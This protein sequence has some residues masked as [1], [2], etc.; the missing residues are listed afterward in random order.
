RT[1]FYIFVLLCLVV[2]YVLLHLFVKSPFG[3]VLIAVKENE[4]RTA[5]LGYKTLYYKVVSSVVA[6]VVASIAG[7]LYVVSLRFVNTSVMAI[8]VTLNSLLMTIIGGVG[9][10]TGPIIGAVIIELAQ[11]NLSNLAKY[12][13]IFERWIIFF[14]VMY[15]LAVIF[16]PHRGGGTEHGPLKRRKNDTRTIH[17]VIK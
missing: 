9:T 6:G 5:A 14:G 10:L 16:L 15:I 12:H 3:S 7:S 13:A 11:H 4:R 17:N 1:T 8:D 2:I